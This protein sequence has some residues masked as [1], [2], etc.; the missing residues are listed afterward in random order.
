ME[1]FAKF[2]AAIAVPLG[3]LNMLGGLIAGIWLAILGNWSVI[4]YGLLALFISSFIL[5]LAMLPG[6]LFAAPA[7]ALHQTRHKIGFYF[8]SFLGAS[9]TMAVLT[10]WCMAVLFLLVRQAESNSIIPI[11]LWSY[12]IATGP[13][14]WMARKEMQSGSGEYSMISTLF[15]QVAYVL[16]AAV[17]L[18]TNASIIDVTILFGTIMLVGLLVQFRIAS[19][20]DAAVDVME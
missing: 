7:L 6:L 16:V 18:L 12:G 17:V 10:A 1:G 11:L 8:F 3:L 14:A 4:G 20:L 5:G 13:I 9:Y 2:A 19:Q 15:S